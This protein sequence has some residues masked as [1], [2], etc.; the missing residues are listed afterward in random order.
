M[1]LEVTLNSAW[2]CAGRRQNEKLA[3]AWAREFITEGS[4][5]EQNFSSLGAGAADGGIVRKQSQSNFQ[6][7]ATGRRYVL[8]RLPCSSASCLIR[9]CRQLPGCKHLSQIS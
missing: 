4:I 8:H 1:D 2:G 6:F 3:K 9:S 5:L 7:Y